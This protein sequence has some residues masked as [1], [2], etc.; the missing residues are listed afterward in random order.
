V[1]SVWISCAQAGLVRE[2]VDGKHL[3]REDVEK[4]MGNFLEILEDEAIDNPNAPKVG[5]CRGHARVVPAWRRLPAACCLRH[6]HA[7]RAWKRRAKILLR[8]SPW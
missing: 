2:L 7:P 8:T 4:G 5:L 6:A 3:L 1:T